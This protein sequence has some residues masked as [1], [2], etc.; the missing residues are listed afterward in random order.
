MLH[1]ATFAA[2]FA[3]TLGAGLAVPSAHAAPATY[4]LDPEP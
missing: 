4:A 2:A 3:A 1:R